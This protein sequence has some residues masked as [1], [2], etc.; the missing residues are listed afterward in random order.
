MAGEGFAG[1]ILCYTGDGTGPISRTG[2]FLMTT[3]ASQGDSDRI[4]RAFTIEGSAMTLEGM[5]KQA[6]ARGFTIMCDEGPPMG[7]N[8]APSPMTYFAV[9]VLF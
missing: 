8:T 2:V 3:P 1:V 7:D 5:K 9:S 6:E 4:S